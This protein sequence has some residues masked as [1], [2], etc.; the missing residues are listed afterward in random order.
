[1]ERGPPAEIRRDELEQLD[2]ERHFEQRVLGAHRSLH[3]IDA[4][5]LLCRMRRH[6]GQH[7]AHRLASTRV[8][9][10]SSRLAERL[11]PGSR[12]KAS[13]GPTTMPCA[14]SSRAIARVS[15]NAA[16]IAT[17]RP[18]RTPLAANRQR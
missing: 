15:S 14:L 9:H 6:A 11:A 10:Q 7:V 13:L 2:V 16:R 1:M 17:A 18:V 8:L 12:Q 5:R 4:E 3:E